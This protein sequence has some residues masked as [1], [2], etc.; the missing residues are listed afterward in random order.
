MS[1][2]SQTTDNKLTISISG[3]FDFG[4][5]KEFRSAIDSINK[6][7]V[8]VFVDLRTT[9]YVDSSALG[10]LLLLK[11]KMN[12]HKDSISLINAKPDV[13]KIL[14]IANFGQLFTLN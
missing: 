14:E 11:N 13:K 8:H 10:M 12:D 3:R 2:S 9:E 1:I 5:H 6:Q 7:T 4:I